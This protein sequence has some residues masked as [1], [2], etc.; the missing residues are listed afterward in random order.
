MSTL[1]DWTGIDLSG[2]KRFWTNFVNFFADLGAYTSFYY[3]M[4]Q[5]QYSL[6]NSL[7]KA[8]ILANR[9]KIPYYVL[10]DKKYTVL[11][12]RTFK[13]YKKG[14]NAIFRK[15]ASFL[16]LEKR[17]LHIVFPNKTK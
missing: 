2:Y 17:A 16:E 14:K 13:M 15:D 6:E 8:K 12:R 1:K 5:G 9:W 11:N 3:N 7:R 4:K 10:P